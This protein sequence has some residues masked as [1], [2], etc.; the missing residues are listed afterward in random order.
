VVTDAYNEAFG[1][2]ISWDDDAIIPAGHQTPFKQAL[3]IV[4]TDFLMKL[5]VP[6][7]AFGFTQRLR[8]AK[9]AF[10]ELQ[11]LI[12][13][14]A[15]CMQSNSFTQSYMRD[16]IRDRLTATK[17][18]RHDLFSSLLDANNDDSEHSKLT[19][20]E[21]ISEFPSVPEPAPDD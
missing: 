15:R 14:S 9:L 6:E 20:N 16:M 17:I 5:I 11:V 18:E 10:E 13:F 8:D 12:L 21:L 7:W 1:R 19:E 3:H 4:S 2:K